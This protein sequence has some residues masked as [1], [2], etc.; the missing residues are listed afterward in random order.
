ML[1]IS[2]TEPDRVGA[3]LEELRADIGVEVSIHPIER[4]VL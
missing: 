3:A 1:E 4:D 2:T